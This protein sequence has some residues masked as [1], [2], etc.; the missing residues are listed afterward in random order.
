MHPWRGPIRFVKAGTGTGTPNNLPGVYVIGLE[1]NNGSIQAVYVGQGNPIRDR[2]N[3]HKGGN[4]PNEGLCEFFNTYMYD[5]AVYYYKEVPDENTRNNYEHTLYLYYSRF[6]KL[7][8]ENVPF[9][10]IIPDI[11]PPF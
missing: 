4:E 3:V 1:L 9:G 8:N 11:R 2:I 6:N 5:G 7:C 10:V